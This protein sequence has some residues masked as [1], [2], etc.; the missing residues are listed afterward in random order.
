MC[1]KYKKGNI[2]KGLSLKNKIIIFTTILITAILCV[3]IFSHNKQIETARALNPI[4]EAE[5]SNG[6][7]EKFSAKFDGDVIFSAEKVLMDVDGDYKKGLADG[8]LFYQRT[9]TSEAD[10][11]ARYFYDYYYNDGTVLDKKYVIEDGS[12]VMLNN[13]V[14]SSSGTP[15]YYYSKNRNLSE[16]IMISFGNYIYNN[17]GVSDIIE[18]AD[19]TKTAQIRDLKVK[20]YKNTE[21]SNGLEE[22]KN[23]P[24]ARNVGVYLDFLYTIPQEPGNEG[25]YRFE[26]TYLTNIGEAHTGTFE[27]YLIY[28]TSYVEEVSF[29]NSSNKYFVQPTLGWVDADSSSFAK[30]SSGSYVRYSAGKDGIDT[31]QKTTSY[32]TITYDYSRYSFKYKHT[33][34][35]VV[36]NYTYTY[37]PDE[38]KITYTA[39]IGNT[40]NGFEE[41]KVLK[42][43]T[44]T[45]KLVTIMLTEPGLY[46]FEYDYIYTLNPDIEIGLEVE[47]LDSLYIHGADLVYSKYNYQSAKMRSLTISTNEKDKV[48]LIVPNAFALDG[49]DNKNIDEYKN[50][51][52]GFVYNTIS[53]STARVGDIINTSAD[54]TLLNIK[55]KS[56]D[57]ITTDTVTTSDYDYLINSNYGLVRSVFG[58]NLTQDS[59]GDGKIETGEKSVLDTSGNGIVEKTEYE[60][61]LSSNIS[62][63]SDLGKVLSSINKYPKTNQGSL[64]FTRNDELTEIAGDNFYFYSTEKFTEKGLFTPVKNEKGEITGYE[65]TKHTFNNE[66]SFNQI[67]YYLVFLKVQPKGT[68]DGKPN[69]NDIYSYYQIFAF[70]YS[71]STVN[72]TV[73]EEV[74]G[75]DETDEKI[76]GSEK[77]TRE[78]VVASWVEPGVFER[79]L[80]AKVYTTNNA[81]DDIAT[82]VRKNNSYAITNND[83]D[84]LI[85]K[86]I[87][88][89]NEG[90]WAKLLIEVK[91]E[92]ESATY[93]IFTIDRQN[94]TGVAG[95]VVAKKYAGNTFYYTYDLDAYG[96]SKR[97]DNG[98]TDSYA[99][100]N[101]NKKTSGAKITVKYTVT[102][103]EKDNS[104]T[105]QFDNNGKWIT[106]NYKL[107]E[108]A[109]SFDLKE[110][111][112]QSYLQ[113]ASVIKDHG[114]HIFTLTDE[115]GNTCKYALVID[116]TENFFYIDSSPKDNLDNGEF[117][118]S[119]SSLIYSDD[120]SYNIAEYK[121]FA[122]TT[123][124]PDVKKFL[125]AVKNND[126]EDFD[127]YI[128]ANS[129][130][131]KLK[132]IF[133]YNSNNSTHYLTIKNNSVDIYDNYG[134]KISSNSNFSGEIKYNDESEGTSTIASIFVKGENHKYSSTYKEYDDTKSKLTVEINLD[135]AR[136]TV[137]YNSAVMHGPNDDNDPNDDEDYKLDTGKVAGGAFATN[138]EYVGFSWNIG[139]GT[140]EVSEVS[141][142]FYELSTVYDQD[143]SDEDGNTYFYQKMGSP[144]VVYKNGAFNEIIGAKN[145]GDGRGFVPF[146][147]TSATAEGLYA[148]TRIYANELP[149][150]DKDT[151]VLTYYFIV[152]RKTIIET[153]VG[154]QIHFELLEE[155][156]FND[157]S[158]YA[159]TTAYIGEEINEYF[160]IYLSTTKLPATLHVPTGKYF[161][162]DANKTTGDY[163]AGQ[164][165]FS[166]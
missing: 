89:V 61:W 45:R 166:L 50:S 56:T 117:F 163:K 70:E 129:N 63:I 93:K 121:A 69:Q 119:N 22:I 124:N 112:N 76:V 102:E 24:P 147:N 27:F 23:L 52:I 100:L 157:F 131:S 115:A 32:P 125:D 145:L 116:R 84:N 92:G 18:H 53:S 36:T 85:G 95:Y 87:A 126:L 57:T 155:T 66:T 12:F 25:Y 86:D 128:G 48:D 33:A 110:A 79:K 99:T 16:V 62:N 143:V 44:S 15:K 134:V 75:V 6:H 98:V 64:W 31:I 136:G 81:N 4:F 38:D 109:G 104:I 11:E 72:I 160:P 8:K 159:G 90:D 153:G 148:V 51:A 29:T 151:Q 19:Q 39:K 94:I 5:L 113:S 139:I 37:Y 43:E 41:E 83:K 146:G 149:D 120:I 140:Y 133:A 80:S 21:T 123:N 17:N 34:N 30:T 46:E 165:N 58:T 130:Y 142:Q 10:G 47:P 54:D 71:T 9:S 40:N 42:Y 135:N 20:A 96:N 28:E 65:T 152:D 162:G 13:S 60:T 14:D 35:D 118:A 2:L 107:G 73:R 141:Y 114:L 49:T 91:S 105:P 88:N 68:E 7:K 132:D 137:T 55:L 78:N 59:N 82:I 101:W 138:A 111:T 77:Y 127:Y 164:L 1:K 106:T 150:G 154:E 97:I 26:F 122:L 67:G 108:T 156:T 144:I 161:Y 3:G 158:S 74:D 103:F